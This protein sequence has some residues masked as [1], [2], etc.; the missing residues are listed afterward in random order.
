MISRLKRLF[1]HIVL[2]LLNGKNR[3]RF[4]KKIK[5]FYSQGDKCEFYITRFGTEPYL[6]KIHNNVEIA[7]G[8]KLITHDDSISMVKRISEFKHSLDS[9]GPIEIFDDSFIGSNSVIMPNVKI[10]PRSIV[11]AGSI[12]TKDVEE[13]TVVAGIPAR[14][15]SSFEDF[16]DKKLKLSQDYPWIK[17][18]TKDVKQ[19]RINHFWK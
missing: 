12:V 6:I 16:L 10:G 13:G 15:I 3:A 2:I 18:S 9:V 11:A 17:S 1:I 7:S 4:L 5:Y 14:K 19:S 8:V